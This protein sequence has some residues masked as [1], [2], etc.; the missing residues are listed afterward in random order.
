MRVWSSKTRPNVTEAVGTGIA[1]EQ[2][3]HPVA[4]VQPMTAEEYKA[5]CAEFERRKQ[6]EHQLLV[7]CILSQSGL[8]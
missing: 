8:L 7:D 3:K 2:V 4:T 1:K 6:E 5:H